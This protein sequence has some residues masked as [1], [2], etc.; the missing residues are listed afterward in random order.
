[1]PDSTYKIAPDA[2]I[3]LSIGKVSGTVLKNGVRQYLGVPYAEPLD[4]SAPREAV[5]EPPKPLEMLRPEMQAGTK[6]PDTAYGLHPLPQCTAGCC[7]CECGQSCAFVCC[8]F[9]C[10]ANKE[11][12]DGKGV[13]LDV[14]RMNIWTPETSKDGAVPVLVWIHGGGDAGNARKDD[15]NSRSGDRLAKLQGVVVCAIEF[16]QG[17]FGQMDWGSGSDVPSNL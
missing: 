14:L 1:M 17:I 4:A 16:R 10:R 11:D 9:C 13:G 5:F 6:E 15:P 7:C 2:N 8:W 12:N 3:D